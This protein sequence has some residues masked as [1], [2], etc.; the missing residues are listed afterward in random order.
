MCFKLTDADG[1]ALVN[2]EEEISASET[3]NCKAG[4]FQ[5]LANFFKNLFKIG[6]I[7]VQSIA[8]E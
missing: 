7:V 8:F 4:L 2:A 1:T 3:I 6:R 5:K